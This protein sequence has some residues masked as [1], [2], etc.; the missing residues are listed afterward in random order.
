M[1]IRDRYRTLFGLTICLPVTFF[2]SNEIT[3]PSIMKQV[4][5]SIAAILSE[6][7]F[8]KVAQ[9]RSSHF[10]LSG[11]VL[12][13]QNPLDP[14]VDRKS[15]QPLVGKEHDTISNLRAHTG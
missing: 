3:L 1:C 4:L 5:L 8:A 2:Q 15:S 14:N 6:I 12:F 11:K 13:S 7:A 9:L 10:S